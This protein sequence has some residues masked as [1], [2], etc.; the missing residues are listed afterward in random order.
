MMRNN[1]W[2]IGSHLACLGMFALVSQGHAHAQGREGG[3]ALLSHQ[4]A[5]HFAEP[6]RN[7]LLDA[8]RAGDRVVVVGDRGVV[9]LSD[10]GGRTYRQ[11]RAV[12]TRATLTAVSF[13]DALNG[14]AAGHWGVILHTTDGGETW[15]LQREDTAVDQPLFSIWFK[16][17][18]S[19]YAT[20]LWSLLLSTDDGGETWREVN[21]PPA[22]DSSRADR[23]LFK[24]FADERANLFIAAERGVVYKSSDGGITDRKSVV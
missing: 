16:D 3:A 9:L 8:T 24:V 4:P 18:R 2:K 7:Q 6:A 19:G 11:A 5:V 14:W 15:S 21:V 17:L 23:N 20:G 13:A 1:F 22:A 12:P 10:D